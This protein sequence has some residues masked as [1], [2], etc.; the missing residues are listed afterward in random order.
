MGSVRL[1]AIAIAEVRE[2]FGAPPEL[3]SRLRAVAAETLRSTTRVP[4]QGLLGKLGPVFVRQP[5]A[6]V[7]PVSAP[8][9]SDLNLLL[10]GRHVPPHRLAAAWTLLETWLAAESWGEHSAALQPATLPALDFDLA[11]AGVPT[12]LSLGELVRR[13]LGL[14][15]R[16]APGLAAGYLPNE[17][18]RALATA[19]RPVLAN[20]EPEHEALV[21]GLLTWL[22]AFPAWTEQAEAVQR[23]PPD[24]VAV[25]RS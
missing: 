20:L 23:K 25:V 3:A 22:D 14:P 17:S 8:V 6:P 19:W 7:F 12:R 10:A 2:F 9:E 16:P 11:K 21:A 24:L 5:D 1:F 4:S 15:L 18:A 13:D